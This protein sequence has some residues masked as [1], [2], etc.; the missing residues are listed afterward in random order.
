MLQVFKENYLG[1]ATLGLLLQSCMGG[2]AAMMILDQQDGVMQ[3]FQMI[4]TVGCCMMYNAAMIANFRVNRVFN[5][6]IIS[7]V[8]SG[9]VIVISLL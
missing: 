5:L 4:L 6:L 1:Y 7:I 2:I 3:K 8:V 9:I